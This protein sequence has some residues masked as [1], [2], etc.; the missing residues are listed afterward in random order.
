[1]SFEEIHSVFLSS[2]QHL[3]QSSRLHTRV[4]ECHGPTVRTLLGCRQR[5]RMVCVKAVVVRYNSTQVNESKVSDAAAPTAVDVLQAV[6]TEPT[7]AELGL[8]ANTPVGLIQNILEYIHINLGLPWWGAI[9]LGTVVVRL[10]VFPIMVKG[11]REAAK[12]NNIMPDMVRLNNKMSEAKQSGNKFEFAKAYSELEMCQKKHGVNSLK[13]FLVPFVQA[14]IF[15]SFFLAL[16]K[17][18]QLPVPSLQTEGVLWFPD[19]TLGDPLYILPLAVSGTMFFV[20]HMG[21]ESGIDNPNLRIMKAVNK[22]M[23]VIIFFVTI[24]FPTAVSTYW[25]TSNCF[26]LLQVSL[27]KQPLIRKKLNIPSRIVHPP[28]SIP[29]QKGFMET[30]SESWKNAK[31]AQQMQERDRRIKNHLELSSKGP[32]R[33]TFTHNPL[34]KSA[35][36]SNDTKRA[37]VK[38][39]PWKDTVV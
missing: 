22:V 38:A 2:S 28:S 27:L 11:Q 30:L 6:A 39:K 35:P 12:L 29:P 15:L 13:T 37:A 36:L 33:Q 1:M 34:H 14:P 25:L 10:V 31:A 3:H 5:G 18:A 21:A 19:L 26:S 20:L 23:P 17:M 16:K 9:V 7:F 8:G 32:L 4:L 24:N